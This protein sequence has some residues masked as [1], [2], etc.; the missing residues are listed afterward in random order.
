ML[1]G[2]SYSGENYLEIKEMKYLVLIEVAPQ[3]LL[4]D[5]LLDRIIPMV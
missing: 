1:T 3:I 2:L 4:F 5:L